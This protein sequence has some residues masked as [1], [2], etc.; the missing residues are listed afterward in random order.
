ML[1][2]LEKRRGSL[3]EPGV[4]PRHVRVLPAE[5]KGSSTV[6]W[7]ALNG[8][9]A[10]ACIGMLASYVYEKGFSQVQPLADALKPLP[11]PLAV[12]PASMQPAE[13][14]MGAVGLPDAPPAP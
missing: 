10:F 6:A 4:V 5:R 1:R 13:A 14:E 11:T 8:A 12:G 2:D 9:V 7:R 3:R